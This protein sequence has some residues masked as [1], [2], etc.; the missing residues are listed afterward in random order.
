MPRHILRRSAERRPA[1]RQRELGAAWRGAAFALAAA[2]LAAVMGATL[3]V[4]FG[5]YDV[6][7]SAPHSNL[8][9]WA[10]HATMIRSIRTRAATIHAPQRFSQAQAARGFGEYERHCVGC[11]GAPGVARAPWASGLTPTPPYLIDATRKWTPAELRLIVGDGVKMT[12]MPA[13]KFTLS[14]DRLWD[15]VAFLET[16]GATTPRQ[17]ARMRAKARAG[18]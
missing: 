14:D 16:L 1:L 17:Y 2:A 8:A 3:F 7:A 11:H 18:S 4:W 15:L 6:S 5:V 10:I 9:A 12:A 13:W